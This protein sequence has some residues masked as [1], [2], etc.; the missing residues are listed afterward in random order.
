VLRCPIE[1]R[2]CQRAASRAKIQFH[3]RSE[4]SVVRSEDYKS[5]IITQRRGVPITLGSLGTVQEGVE[6][7]R[8][9]GWADTSLGGARRLQ[10]NRM[11]R[12]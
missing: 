4:R 9:A 10:S 1:R 8:Q 12:D 5:L 11:P 6:N 3:H 2:I 7:V